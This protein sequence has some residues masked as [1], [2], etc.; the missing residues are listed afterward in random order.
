MTAIYEVPVLDRATGDERLVRVEAMSAEEASSRVMR[1]GEAAGT[2]RLAE[3]RRE[4]ALPGGATCPRCGDSEWSG[5]RGVFFWVAVVLFFPLGLLLLFVP[6]EYRCKTCQF[7][8][9]T[10]RNLSRRS[11]EVSWLTAI[12]T[13]IGWLL[14]GL[15]GLFVVMLVANGG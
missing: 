8:F 13:V 3:V 4:T 1:M 15:F 9:R 11:G 12:C 7:A 5:G 14:I 10:T 2:A 6:T